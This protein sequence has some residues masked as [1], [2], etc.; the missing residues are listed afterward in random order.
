MKCFKFYIAGLAALFVFNS[1]SKQLDLLPEDDIT[2]EQFW[3]TPND[4]KLYANQFYT[5]FPVNSGYFVSPFWADINSDDM[6]PGSYNVRMAGQNTILTSNG[7]WSFNSIRNVNFGLQN[8]TRVTGNVD[9][10][11]AGFGELKFFKAYYYY[12]LLKAYGD[13]PWLSKPLEIDSDELFSARTPRNIVADSILRDL[14][15]AIANL[16]LKARAEANRLNKECALLFKSR[17]A[18]YEGSWE[19][20]HAGTA[21][22]VSNGNPAHYFEAAAKAAED[23]MNLGSLR[24]YQPANHTDYFGELFGNTDLSN[25]SEILLWKKH[26]QAL[27]MAHN[28]QGALYQG[29]DRGLSKSLVE[30][31]LASDGL[32]ISV[33]PN[34]KGDNTLTDIVANRDPRLAQTFWVP[35][36]PFS[37]S[38]SGAVTAYFTLPWIDRT[39]E[40]RNTSGYQ[41]TK[42]RTVNR[43]M[44]MADLQTASIVFRYA[45]CL[46][47]FAEAKAGL[48]TITQA[49]LDKSLNLL[50]DRVKMPHLNMTNITT[51]PRWM[52]PELS[53][54]INEIR[55]ERRVELA[56]EGY[57]F[58]DL[59]RWA[60][61]KYIVDTRPK[62]YKFRQADFPTIVIGTNIFVD[63]NGYLDPYQRSLPNG[64]KFR[65]DRD[66]LLAVPQQEITLNPNLNQNPQ[67]Q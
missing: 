13:V 55:R 2:N 5:S 9:E 22:G 20:Y 40:T 65:L 17:V 59:M 44:G 61:M 8:Y 33:S 24:L 19:K 26:D 45:E 50:R 11:K 15:T 41:L 32:P 48:G 18:L 57:R 63:P 66:Y 21:F 67:W 51:D 53:G 4:L 56:A 49:D 54:L 64:F 3:N 36:V 58:D 52:F 1:C 14:D 6:I 46:L 43:Q 31:F 30:S 60:A 35:G 34:Y 23:L 16:P 39:G 29:G 38:A 12:N 42:G 7:S 10:I 25:N 62:G 28:I 27:N 47:N 37:Y